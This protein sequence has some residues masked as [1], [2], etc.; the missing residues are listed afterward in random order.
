MLQTAYKDDAIGKTQRTSLIWKK[1]KMS[2][3]D[4]SRSGHPSTSRTDESIEKNCAIVLEDRW[5]T[6]EV[7]CRVV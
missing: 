1:G 5:W 4:K 6:I 7:I 2:I 3:D